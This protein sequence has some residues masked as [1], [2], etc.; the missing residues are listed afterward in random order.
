[1]SIW[2]KEARGPEGVNTVNVEMTFITFM[3]IR[4]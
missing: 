1:M 2:V 4:P 3:L